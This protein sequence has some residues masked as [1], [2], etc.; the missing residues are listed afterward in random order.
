MFFIKKIRPAKKRGS[1]RNQS[2]H[3]L[4]E[5]INAAKIEA[6]SICCHNTYAQSWKIRS[7]ET[8][9]YQRFSARR[10]SGKIISN[11]MVDLIY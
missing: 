1:G 4:F 3:D 6:G 10:M 5:K 9:L 11:R 2:P 7:R 8:C